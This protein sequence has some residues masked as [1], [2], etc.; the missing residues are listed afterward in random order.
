[1]SG[2][3][4]SARPKA[5]RVGPAA[6]NQQRLWLAGRLHPGN[7]SYH[8]ASS[9]ELT[10]DLPV[11]VLRRALGDLVRRHDVLRTT[12][13]EAG[14]ELR[15]CVADSAA[16]RLDVVDLRSEPD[17]EA[18]AEEATAAVRREPTDLET[19]PLFRALLCRTADDR[20]VLT[21][22]VHHILA[23]GWTLGLLWEELGLL[24]GRRLGEVVTLPPTGVAYTQWAAERHAEQGS[25]AAEKELH[26]WLHRLGGLDSDNSL[27]TDRPRP[28]V[29]SFRGRTLQLP[30]PTGLTAALRETARSRGRSLFM[31]LCAGFAA[32][33][34]HYDRREEV[35]VAV[36]SSGRADPRVARTAGFFVNTLPMRFDL[37]GSPSLGHLVEQAREGTL[38]VSAAEH[39]TYEQLTQRT[40]ASGDLSMNPLAQ[41]AF[42]L[43]SVPIPP[44]RFRG[45]RTRRW[46]DT[47]A[48]AKFDLGLM[49]VPAAGDDLTALFSYS[50]ELF[51]ES[52]VRE[53]WQAYLRVLAELAADP[54]TALWEVPLLGADRRREA[55]AVSRGPPCTLR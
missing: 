25:P 38:A 53:I 7:W 1:M 28:A 29:P 41:V 47:T 50:E 31:L 39:V 5:G 27:R 24:F 16:A 42:Q 35:V 18:A 19:G 37:G 26:E 3:T 21:L 17:P 13:E 2:D 23:D 48:A 55:A 22:H 54:G 6:P 52:T 4:G 45:L 11:A 32:T 44:V 20:H 8:I 51:D 40:G 14:G 10:G 34:G 43:M 15:M 12:F 33:L 30:M 36:Q 9:L 46:W 49:M